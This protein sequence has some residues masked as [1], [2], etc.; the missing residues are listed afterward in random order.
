ML[1]MQ[2]AYGFAR[3][4]EL[5]VGRAKEHVHGVAETPRGRVV[6]G[7]SPTLAPLLLPGCVARTRQQSWD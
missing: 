1:D 6:I 2:R 5:E 3:R 7:T 4:I